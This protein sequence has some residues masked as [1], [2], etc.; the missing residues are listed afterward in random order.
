[1]DINPFL[2]D[3]NI[4]VFFSGIPINPLREYHLMLFDITNPQQSKHNTQKAQYVTFKGYSFKEENDPYLQIEEIVLFHFPA[5]MLQIALNYHRKPVFI[6]NGQYNAILKFVRSSKK[7][8]I[9][10]S[11][12]VIKL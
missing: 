8:M 5:R 2:T 1:M 10:N 11:L 7:S 6:K 3:S 12:V 9:I 4:E